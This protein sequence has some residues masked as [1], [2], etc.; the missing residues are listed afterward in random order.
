[1][2][3]WLLVVWIVFVVL[4][5][6][7]SSRGESG[8]GAYYY[9]EYAQ[10]D[11]HDAI[12]LADALT[13][14]AWIE[15][16]SYAAGRP[17]LCKLWDGSSRAYQLAISGTAPNGELYL[18]LSNASGS[19]LQISEFSSGFGGQNGEWC[20]AA[21]SWAKSNGSAKFYKDGALV[22]DSG[23]GVQTINNNNQPLRIATTYSLSSYFY[24]TVGPV[25]IY[26]RELSAAEIQGFY[27][28]SVATTTNGAS[29]QVPRAWIDGTNTLVFASD[30]PEAYDTGDTLTNGTQIINQVGPNPD[31]VGTPEV[32][33]V[34]R[35]PSYNR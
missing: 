13:I 11:D 20:M 34:F 35:V 10:V 17:I 22:S 29:L 27:D 15:P 30:I 7:T 8:R 26:N 2:K 16:I 5:I 12:D 18:A 24:G 1:M 4:A 21:V 9:T 6:L 23:Y 19:N 14:I 32:G 33:V 25:F 3:R 28:I 31:V